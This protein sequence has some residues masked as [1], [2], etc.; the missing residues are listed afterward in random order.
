MG[1]KGKG[2]EEEIGSRKERVEGERQGYSRDGGDGLAEG[3]VG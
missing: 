1:R 2:Q 3:Y